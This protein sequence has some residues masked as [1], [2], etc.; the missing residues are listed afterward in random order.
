MVMLIAVATVYPSMIQLKGEALGKAFKEWKSLLLSLVYV[1]ALAPLM[2]YVLA[3]TLDNRGI[4]LGFM[5]VSVVPAGSASVGYVLIAEESI[6]L[7]TAL[8][9]LGLVITARTWP[10]NAHCT[11]RAKG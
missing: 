7:A 5:V 10:G 11:S 9:T 2:A 4:G 3:P 8:A 1:F 6:E